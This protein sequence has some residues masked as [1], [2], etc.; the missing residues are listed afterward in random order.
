VRYGNVIASTGSVVPLFL[1]LVEERRPLTITHHEM[2]R[3]LLTLDHAVDAIAAAM[4]WARPGET[5]VPKI[6]AA[7]VVDIAHV[8]RGD[9]D[10]PIVYVGIR[11]GEK[12]HEVLVSETE[13]IRTTERD[14]YYVIAPILPELWTNEPREHVLSDIYTSRDVNCDIDQLRDLLSTVVPSVKVG[15]ASPIGA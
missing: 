8:L 12:V 9:L 6:P 15:A 3:F 2:T 11:P 1:R 14:D 5:F 4:R 10:L 7:R 13:R